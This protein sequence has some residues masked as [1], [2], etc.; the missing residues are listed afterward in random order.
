MRNSSIKRVKMK[1]YKYKVIYLNEKEAEFS[2]N[3]FHQAIILAM[4]D[5]INKGN[6]MRIKYITDEQGTSI[7]DIQFP[8]FKFCS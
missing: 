3:G 6:D 7:K 8:T 5:A 1:K 2:C 4:A